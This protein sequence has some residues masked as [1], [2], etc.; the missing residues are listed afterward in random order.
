MMTMANVRW[1]FL[2]YCVF[3]IEPKKFVV[4]NR[5]YKPVGMVTDDWVVYKDYAKTIKG[6]TKAKARKISYKGSDD[7][8]SIYLYNDGCVPTTSKDDWDTYSKR[9]EVLANLTVET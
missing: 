2:P 1:W 5:A 8:T 7:I 4:L 3:M 9:L 6:L